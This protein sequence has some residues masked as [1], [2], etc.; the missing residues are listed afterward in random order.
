VD[1]RRRQQPQ[2]Q[3]R[4]ARQARRLALKV[5]RRDIAAKPIGIGAFWQKQLW[6]YA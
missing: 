6:G 5:S 2:H 3:R 4:E 1:H